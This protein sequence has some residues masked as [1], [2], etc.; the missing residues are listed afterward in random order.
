MLKTFV[1][2]I[3]LKDVIHQIEENKKKE[4]K[5]RLHHQNF[6]CICEDY[7]FYTEKI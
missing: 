7:V 1:G 6:D 2:Y 4:M 5:K 3:D